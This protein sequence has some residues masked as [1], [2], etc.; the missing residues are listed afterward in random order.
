M[1]AVPLT[2]SLT[3]QAVFDAVREV[4]R[5]YHAQPK[6]NPNA[7]CYEICEHF[8][9]RN[10]KGT[11]NPDSADARYTALMETLKAAYSR[12]AAQIEPKITAVR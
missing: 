7:S 3:A 10:A 6:A 1:P 2:F 12:L 5:Y 4:W 11:M 9:G 8:Q